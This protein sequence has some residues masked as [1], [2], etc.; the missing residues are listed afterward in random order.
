M[1][2]SFEYVQHNMSGSR[3]YFERVRERVPRIYTDLIGKT[4]KT[5]WAVFLFSYYAT[6]CRR[7][8]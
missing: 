1:I 8:L 7:I 5:I 3:K 2:L 6:V 4:Y